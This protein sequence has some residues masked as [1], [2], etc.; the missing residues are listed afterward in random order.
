MRIWLLLVFCSLAQA[1]TVHYR[2]VDPTWHV[3]TEFQINT[4][5]LSGAGTSTTAAG[6]TYTG[7]QS[8]QLTFGTATV[9]YLIRVSPAVNVC[10]DSFIS[11]V[12]HVAN[13][14]R[15]TN[16]SA[17]VVALGNNLTNYKAYEYG[18]A[19]VKDT[20]QTHY[21]YWSRWNGT[22]QKFSTTGTYNC[23]AVDSLVLTFAAVAGQDTV[24]M[25]GV[26]TYAPRIDKA[27]LI[28]TVD[29]G[30]LRTIQNLNPTFES[31]GMG[32]TAFLNFGTLGTSPF[33]S[34]AVIDSVWR[35]GYMRI[36]SHWNLHDTL[37]LLTTDSCMRSL[38]VNHNS[39]YG[40]GWGTPNIT[41]TPYGAITRAED[42]ALR[43][44]GMSDFNRS[45]ASNNEGE[46]QQF[47]NPYSMK[48]HIFLGSTTTLTQAKAKVDAAIA[49]K[50]TMLVLIHD[51][52][53]GCAGSLTSTTWDKDTAIAFVN[54]V[55]TKVVAGG[56]QTL[57][58]EDYLTQVFGPAAAPHG[59]SIDM[60]LGIPQ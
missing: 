52:C 40:Q 46:P 54:Y 48:V 11:V 50:T 8:N 22:L 49:A 17:A 5:V 10:A 9:T 30:Y 38:A 16:V 29:D 27:T 37:P 39:I 44:S 12:Y 7:V 57:P 26:Y 35:R 32:W 45:I 3:V 51:I 4:T 58:L 24:T 33:A 31:Y 25:G 53:V 23:A 1:R 41:A 13:K 36:E 15:T 55:Q 14:S 56:L 59:M 34:I 21:G 60:G 43:L 2:E 47:A 20:G 28:W 6:L 42:S 18:S 19:N